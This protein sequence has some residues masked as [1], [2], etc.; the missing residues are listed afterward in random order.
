MNGTYC[1]EANNIP[2]GIKMLIGTPVIGMLTFPLRVAVIVV[3]LVAGSVVTEGHSSPSTA[4]GNK[5]N[6]TT[7][8]DANTT[9][10]PFS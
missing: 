2:F 3:I 5:H 1:N 6:C 4:M 10:K 9:L 7:T 8:S